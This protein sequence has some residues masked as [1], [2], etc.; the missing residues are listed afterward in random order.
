MSRRARERH[1]RTSAV[2]SQ[3]VI[4]ESRISHSWRYDTRRLVRGL[5]FTWV[6]E[7]QATSSGDRTET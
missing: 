4:R 3:P 7:A 2:V 1:G 5:A 6:T